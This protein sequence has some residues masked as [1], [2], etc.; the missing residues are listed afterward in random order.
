MRCAKHGE[1]FHVVQILGGGIRARSEMGM[2]VPKYAVSGVD[3]DVDVG[4]R[5]FEFLLILLLV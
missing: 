5:G 4:S 2:G 1:R 3:V